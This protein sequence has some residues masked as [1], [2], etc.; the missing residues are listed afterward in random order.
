MPRVDPAPSRRAKRD[1]QQLHGSTTT[2]LLARR[3]TSATKECISGSLTTRAPFHSPTTTLQPT[4][5]A[6]R[7]PDELIYI[8]DGPTWNDMAILRFVVQNAF[9]V[10]PRPVKTLDL[11]VCVRCA[12]GKDV[13]IPRAYRIPLLW[14]AN[15]LWTSLRLILGAEPAIR[16]HEWDGAKFDILHVSRL[17]AMLLDSAGVQKRMERSWR[18][19]PFDRA[20][21]RYWYDWLI[22]R[23]DF[24]R[25]FWRDFGEEEYE[26]DVLKLGWSQWVLKEHKGFAL[27]KDE[28]ARGITANQFVEGLVIDENAGTFHWTESL[29]DSANTQFTEIRNGIPLFSKFDVQGAS[30]QSIACTRDLRPPPA[31][32]SIPRPQLLGLQGDGNTQSVQRVA[33]LPGMN[34]K[35]LGYPP[36]R[37]HPTDIFR[38]LLDQA[39]AERRSETRMRDIGDA[40]KGTTNG[41][42]G[43]EVNVVPMEKASISGKEAP[44]NLADLVGDDL[45]LELEKASQLQNSDQSSSA[46]KSTQQRPKNPQILATSASSIESSSS[47]LTPISMS[48]TTAHITSNCPTAV[49]DPR[50]VGPVRPYEPRPEDVFLADVAADS[51]VL[52]R[53]IQA[54][55]EKTHQLRAEVER[56]KSVVMVDSSAVNRQGHREHPLQHL[57]SAGREA[58]AGN[59]MDVDTGESEGTMAMAK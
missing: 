46:V 45:N 29:P 48:L 28:V 3:S 31:L 8:S 4:A 50:F 35:T 19:A 1:S 23:D 52:V 47:S 36:F 55:A 22:M 56:I 14:V 30:D 51:V 39:E 32:D 41:V 2:S 10:P 12:N 9:S 40:N 15:F 37:G 26:G 43:I 38:A 20:L 42:K 13:V 17:C 5:K 27:T 54:W 57:M 44:T 24:V 34:S 7:H 53:L 11:L 18:C 33:Q 16:A 6:W 49:G 58:E 59:T 21:R 25:D